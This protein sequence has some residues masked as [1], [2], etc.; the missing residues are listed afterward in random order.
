VSPGY[1]I[2]GGLLNAPSACLA[3]YACAGGGSVGTAGG[4]VACGTGTYSGAGAAS[5][6]PCPAGSSS[7]GSANALVSSCTVGGGFYA[8]SAGAVSLLQCPAGSACP[9]GG[10]LG[11]NASTAATQ[12]GAGTFSLVGASQCSSCPPGFTSGVG[13]SSCASQCGGPSAPA[14]CVGGVYTFGGDGNTTGCFF[15]TYAGSLSSGAWVVNVSTCTACPAGTVSGGWSSGGGGAVG[16]GGCTA[17]TIRTNATNCTAPGPAAN[18]TV[19]FSG[20]T[21]ATGVAPST[22]D[23]AVAQLEVDANPLFAGN[24]SAGT[25]TPSASLAGVFSC[26]GLR[27]DEGVSCGA[28][29]SAPAGSL[30]VSASVANFSCSGAGAVTAVFPGAHYNLSTSQVGSLDMAYINAY[31]NTTAVPASVAVADPSTQGRFATAPPPGSTGGFCYVTGGGTVTCFG[32]VPVAGYTCVAAAAGVPACSTPVS[33]A[34]YAAAACTATTDTSLSSCSLCN[35][36]FRTAQT[37][38]PGAAVSG[39]GTNTSC[40]ACSVCPA[41]WTTTAACASGNAALLG[42]DTVCTPP[43][44]PGPPPPR[45]PPP[46]PPP[47]TLSLLVPSNYSVQ[48]SAS[49]GGFNSASDFS[50]AHGASFIRVMATLYLHEPVSSVSVNMTGLTF[51]AA[52]SRRT[53]LAMSTL[54]VPFA[55]VAANGSHATS[56]TSGVAAMDPVAFAS[57]LNSDLNASGVSGAH[58]NVVG[59]FAVTAVV[60]PPSPPMNLTA[61]SANITAAVAS[62]T[63]QLAGATGAALQAAQTSV[64]AGLLNSTT[65]LGGANATAL[66]GAAASAAASLVLA[67]VNASNATLSV[68]SQSTALSV[69]ASVAAAPINVTGPAGEVLVEAL[70]IIAAS[71]ELINPA[72]LAKVS[73]VLDLLVSNVASSLL[74]ALGNGTVA[75]A[76]VNFFSPNIQVAVSL[77]PPGVVSTSPISAPGSLSSFDA[78]PPGLLSAASG[79]SVLT[80]FRSLAFDPYINASSSPAAANIS[81]VGGVTRLAFST[82]AGPLVVANATTPITFT[83]PAVPTAGGV[84]QSVC[85]FYDTAA[86][87]YS[88]A[89]CVGVPN[90]GPAG[91]TLGFVPGY[92]TPSDAS[93]AMAWNITGPLLAGCNTTLVDCSLP[94]PPVVYPDPRQPLAIPAVSCP[95]P[96]NGTKPPVLRVFYGTHCQLWQPGN[97]YNCS[98]NNT[99]QAFNGTGCVAT[100]NVTKCMCRHLTDFAAAR[101]P[102]LT[103]CSLSDLL[104]LNPADIVTKLKFLFI[105]RSSPTPLCD[106]KLRVLTF[107]HV[108]VLSSG[109]RGAVRRDEHRR[110]GGL[111]ARRPRAEA[112]GPAAAAPGDGVRGAA[113]R[114]VDVDVQAAAA[115]QPD[116]GAPRVGPNSRLPHG[117]PAHPPAHR[118]PRRAVRHL[119]RTGRGTGPRGRPVVAV[120]G[121][122]RGQAQAGDKAVPPIQPH[123][124]SFVAAV[125]DDAAT[126]DAVKSIGVGALHVWAI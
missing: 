121:Q 68:Q 76:T 12:C 98:W 93:L 9:G 42:T 55:V 78:M 43:P 91:H 20:G 89:G 114:R 101:T 94:H 59:S 15:G 31:L 46:S 48:A 124:A 56:I 85:A 61:D 86:G 113:G 11:V 62:V 24:V 97:A 117:H 119:G 53:M 110:G 72:A 125:A 7:A 66:S 1:F 3:G 104:S 79:A 13:D 71:A 5:C 82:A 100:G 111:H 25:C 17:T 99:L 75:P 73:S 90:P 45:P 38:S 69:L 29:G 37:C 107:P 28:A 122:P 64:L 22:S 6:S 40:T 115:G 19:T 108:R 123:V 26:T 10:S 103:T 95:V 2:A 23:L 39:N 120:H 96:A 88:T 118:P 65:P 74:S 27:A 67:V 77:A 92:Q 109:G 112:P 57:D 30:N 70:S 49:L 4:S 44:P 36:G 14:S 60:L 84:N 16:A 41:G 83:L 33:N 32:F 126:V 81:T 50:G 52:G 106:S 116:R 35:S 80:E 18:I 105:V 102:K 54:A 63:A 87:A 34:T 8:A 58:I 21:Q 47:P 51:S